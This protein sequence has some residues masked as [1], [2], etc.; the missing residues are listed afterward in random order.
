MLPL[1]KIE[2]ISYR[3]NLNV[4]FFQQKLN[5]IQTFGKEV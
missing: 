2:D 3:V 1:K 4:D 5:R